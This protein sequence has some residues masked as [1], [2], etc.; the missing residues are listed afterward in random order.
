[1]KNKLIARKKILCI[2]LI[3]L[4]LVTLT[5]CF[6]NP[7]S[8]K[9]Q[10]MNSEERIITDCIGRKV[11]I[12]E[13]PVRV[14][15]LD[16]FAGEALVMI[17]A[18]DKMV[19]APNGVKM[20]RLLQRIYPDLNEIAVPMSGGNINAESL[21]EIKPDLILL[22][23]SFYSREGEIE[24][25]EKT[26]IP[27]L[28]IS[29]KNMEEQI[30]ALQIIGEALGGEAEKKATDINDYYRSVIKKAQQI[31]KK[32]P[33]EKRYRVYHSINEVIRT[34]GPDTLGYDWINCVGAVNVSVGGNLTF[35]E[36]DYYTSMEQIFIW[37]PDIVIC[38]EATTMKYFLEDSKWTGLRAVYN[39]QVYNIPVGATRWGQRGSLETFLAI[40][41]LGTTIYPEYYDEI[42]LKE[43]VF[44]FYKD[45][46]GLELDDETYN[47]ILKGEG[48]REGSS[49]FSK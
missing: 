20:D 48:I 12:P 46:L 36:N 2:F 17:G 7:D 15:A 31:S 22:K 35:T 3:I 34:D 11:K 19:S 6:D 43:E 27:Y 49:N 18:G 28:V 14:A 4:Q 38:N 8:D 23:G 32:I 33:E 1:M 30:Y 24:K 42:D 44:S 47:Q 29:Y 45:Y 37:D 16:S 41:W 10:N 39:N 21:M 5:G 26:G 13:T 25:I 9:K 40:I